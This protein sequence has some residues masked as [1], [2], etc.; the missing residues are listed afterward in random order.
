MTNDAITPTSCDVCQQRYW[1]T[2]CRT[3]VEE[4]E[5]EAFLTDLAVRG[6][7]AWLNIPLMEGLD[8]I[9]ERPD[10]GPEGRSWLW[11]SRDGSAKN[12]VG[13]ACFGCG[14]WTGNTRLVSGS[15][16]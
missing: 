11:G 4:V 9:V 3:I 12:N 14:F 1:G 13:R 6:Q 8:V 2:I 15:H 10:G 5:V 16:R 7:V